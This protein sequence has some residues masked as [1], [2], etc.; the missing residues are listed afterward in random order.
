MSDVQDVKDT[1]A[2][3]SS[4]GEQGEILALVAPL[5][6]FALSRVGNDHDADDVVQET[7]VRVLAARGRLEDGTLTA[8]AFTVARNVIATHARDA[9][10]GRRHAPRLVELR[11][12]H[13]PEQLA[14]AAED[15]RALAAALGELPRP[16]RDQLVE[17]VVHETPLGDLAGEDGPGPAALAL[18]R[19]TLPTAR[20]RPV[21]LAVSAGDRRR[22][23]A[24]RAGRHLL[25]CA[26]CADLGEPLLQ[27]R[28][29]LA[30]VVPWVPLGAWHGRAVGWIREH[31]VQSTVAAGSAVAAAAAAAV[32]AVLGGPAPAPA[33]SPAAQ[34]PPAAAAPAPAPSSRPPAGAALVLAASGRDV[35]PAADDLAALAGQPVRARAVRVLAVSADEGFWVGDARGRVWVS[36]SGRGES[37]ERIRA[38]QRVSFV[39]TVVRH[40]RTFPA[41]AGVEDA[42]GRRT[43]L[44]QG[45]HIAVRSGSITRAAG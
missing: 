41:R 1:S 39:G 22:Q 13:Q 37:G 44:R 28:R 40:D 23:A 36:L 43:L 14:L 12:P 25:T 4:G 31:P 7:L 26:V 3:P 38:G 5:R 27:R 17:H 10:T 35:L 42:E 24:L 11:E 9:D 34:R 18:R 16:Q 21:L 8:Y 15:R 32:A 20:C 19:V 30:G 45:A 33:P 29:A 6:R 2:V